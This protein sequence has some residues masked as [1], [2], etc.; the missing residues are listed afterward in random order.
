MINIFFWSSF[1]CYSCILFVC[2]SFV[3][4][5]PVGPDQLLLRGAM[6]RNTRWVFGKLKHLHSLFACSS[7]WYLLFHF[8]KWGCFMRPHEPTQTYFLEIELTDR[9]C[10]ETES[11]TAQISSGQNRTEPHMQIHAAFAV[12][13]TRGFNQMRAS[14]SV[15]PHASQCPPLPL[16]IVSISTPF[17]WSCTASVGKLYCPGNDNA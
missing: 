3:R 9:C 17:S 1:V 8:D 5:V 13:R 12:W 16:R 7:C 15:F 2:Y 11:V 14:D 10:S 4:T 6:L